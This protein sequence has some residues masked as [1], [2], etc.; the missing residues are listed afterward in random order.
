M[1]VTFV[2]VMCPGLGGEMSVITGGAR[3]CS[4]VKFLVSDTFQFLAE[5]SS[6]Q[7]TYHWNV[8]LLKNVRLSNDFELP[9]GTLRWV[10][11]AVPFMYSV[12]STVDVRSSVTL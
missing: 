7:F 5:E 8:P 12:Q 1:K 9:L 2:A 4:T 10:V 6:V 3:S 11:F